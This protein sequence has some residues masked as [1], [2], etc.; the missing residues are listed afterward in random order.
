MKL[1]KKIVPLAVASGLGLSAMLIAAPAAAEVS[2]NVAVSNMYLW[3]GVN[4]AQNGGTVSGGLDYS[5]ESG[6]YAGAWTSSESGG[7]ETDL[8]LGFSGEASGVGYDVGYIEYLYPEDGTAP[9]NGLSDTDVSEVYLSG[10]YGPVTLSANFVTDSD[11]DDDAYYALS[12]EFG[13]TSV[14]LGVWD[15]DDPLSSNATASFGG[16][17]Y[18]H[19][20]FDYAATDELSFSVSFASPDVTDA[21]EEDPLF[22]VTYAKSFEL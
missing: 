6:F 13:K 17:E 11:Y 7:H 18:S 22:V 4:L 10:S 8:Y 15:I 20:T 16:A 3:R 9:L 2:A 12:G 19:L 5:H 21:V 1:S 14:T